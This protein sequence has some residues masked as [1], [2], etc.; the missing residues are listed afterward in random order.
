MEFGC[1]CGVEMEFG[2]RVEME[3]AVSTEQGKRVETEFKWSLGAAE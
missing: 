2:K 1:K 3:F